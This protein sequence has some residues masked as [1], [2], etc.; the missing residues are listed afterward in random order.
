MHHH[1]HRD[2]AHSSDADDGAYV[3]VMRMMVHTVVM[4]MRE[5]AMHTVLVR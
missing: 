4:V 5:G 2:G 1:T 3:M